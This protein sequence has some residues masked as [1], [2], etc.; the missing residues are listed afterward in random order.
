MRE[1]HILYENGLP[2]N[3]V[4]SLSTLKLIFQS[5]ASKT[6][7]GTVSMS[8]S[9]GCPALIALPSGDEYCSPMTGGSKWPNPICSNGPCLAS[10]GGLLHWPWI[11]NDAGT[12]GALEGL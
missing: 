1:D 3:L 7:L 5:F 2:S 6:L 9:S 10:G 12:G 11:W 4:R 8:W